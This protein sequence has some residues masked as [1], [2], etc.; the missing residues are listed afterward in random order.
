MN[1]SKISTCVH[2]YNTHVG[3]LFVKQYVHAHTVH[4]RCTCVYTMYM[5]MYM[6]KCTYSET[7]LFQPHLLEPAKVAGLVRWLDFRVSLLCET[8]N[9][10]QK[11]LAA[12]V[13]WPHFRGLD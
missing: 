2:V 12:L 6:Y 5:Y 10:C 3:K 1:T 11:A 13:K 9:P 4:I 8:Y 7:S